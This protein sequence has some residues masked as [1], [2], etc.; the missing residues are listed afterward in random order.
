MVIE[1]QATLIAGK[2]SYAV[3]AGYSLKEKNHEVN[4]VGFKE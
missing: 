4:S 2:N 1:Y 3:Q